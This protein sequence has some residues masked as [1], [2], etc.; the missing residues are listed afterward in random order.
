MNREALLKKIK[1]KARQDKKNRRDPRFLNVLGFL[2]AKGFLQTNIDVR[3]APNRHLRIEDALWAGQNVEPR[4]LE[5]LPAAVLRLEKHFDLDPEKHEKLAQLVAQLRKGQ[6]KGDAF[7][8][9]PYDKI[10]VWTRLPLKDGRMK[11]VA[12]KKVT[13]T[14]RIKPAA[15]ARLKE[16]A[17]KMNCTETEAL[18][19]KLLEL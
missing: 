9:I 14:F 3:P 12:E 17:K 11:A 16:I 4:I 15:L 6:E 13:K 5:V 8:E 7:Y 19:R 1:E 2:V 10:K 18:E